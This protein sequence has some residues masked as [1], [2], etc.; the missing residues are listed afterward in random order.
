MNNI[1]TYTAIVMSVL[2]ITAN[3]FALPVAGS[4]VVTA[5][6]DL[7]LTGTQVWD[8]VLK[9]VSDNTTAASQTAFSWSGVTAGMQSYKIADQY[10]ELTTTITNPINWK[11]IIYTDNTNYSGNKSLGGFGIVNTAGSRGLPLAWKVQETTATVATPVF[12]TTRPTTP[13][14][15]GFTDFQWKFLVDKN[16]TDWGAVNTAKYNRVW[17]NGGFYWNEG[18][19][20]DLDPGPAVAPCPAQSADGK[21]NVY[22]GAGFHSSMAETYATTSL[23]LDVLL[24]L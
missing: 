21:V 9:K 2:F 18:I 5:S 15:E 3:S 8:A 19:D 14:S 6:I 13:V 17:D 1:K 7:S 22:I 4:K 20:D 11:M 24:G 12:S 23:T 16:Q 10:I